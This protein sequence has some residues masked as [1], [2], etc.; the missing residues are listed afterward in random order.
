[1]RIHP[2]CNVFADTYPNAELILM[3]VE[4][5]APRSTPKGVDPHEIAS[6]A[7]AEALL[8]H[9]Y[10]RLDAGIAEAR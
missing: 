8:L 4:N 1:M 6:M 3:G 5:H 7:L 9:R 10:K 2:L